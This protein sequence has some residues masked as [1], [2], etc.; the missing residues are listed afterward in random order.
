M[1]WPIAQPESG[2]WFNNGPTVIRIS[3]VG[4]GMFGLKSLRYFGGRFFR[5][6]SVSSWSFLVMLSRLQKIEI[7]GLLLA[8][9]SLLPT[10]A[11]AQ[12]T[13]DAT[14]GTESSRVRPGAALRRGGT[15]DLIEGGATRGANLFHS[16]SEF[17]VN[18]GQRVYFANPDGIANILSRVTGTDV[19]DIRGTLGV[20]GSANLFFLNPN[21]INFGPDARLDVLG[22]FLATTG[23]DF[24]F[25]GGSTFGTGNPQAPSLLT[26]SV[27]V[28]VQYGGRVPGAIVVDGAI[29]FVDSGK[30]LIL[31]GG[32]I[33]LDNA[34]LETIELATGNFPADGGRVELGAASAGTV[35]INQNG[36]QFSLSFPDST[37]RSDISIVNGSSIDVRAEDK[38]AISVYAR[39]LEMLSGGRLRAGVIAFLSLIQYNLYNSVRFA[40]HPN[41]TL[42]PRLASEGCRDL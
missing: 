17:N 21:G 26:V 41:E 19:S 3:T 37:L 15:A 14:L 11:M 30:S 28:G 25:P 12:I 16:F 10:A 13:P 2:L 29:L 31:A 5:A 23:N 32:T 40:Y 6:N 33:R 27:P 9:T 42:F 8:Y 36:G 4:T 38:G 18:D 22:S 24:L 39:N 35:G 1:H 20:D 7:A 34:L